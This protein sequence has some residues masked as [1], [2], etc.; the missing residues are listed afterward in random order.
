MRSWW[1]YLLK[2]GLISPAKFNRLTKTKMFTNDD[3]RSKFVKRQLVE[4][5]QITKYV[6]NILNN[7]YKNTNVFFWKKFTGSK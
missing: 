3:D 7:N 4:T 5:R 2:N 6:T 1:E